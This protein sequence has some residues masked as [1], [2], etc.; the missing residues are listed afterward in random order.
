MLPDLLDRSEQCVLVTRGKNRFYVRT[1]TCDEE[2]IGYRYGKARFFAA[3][4]RSRKDDV[5]F[6]VGAHIGVFA[7]AAA[8]RVPHGRVYAMEPDQ[9][10]FALLT[11]N[12]ALNG[13]SNL[14]AHRIAL[15]DRQGKTR[16]YRQAESWAHSIC[17]PMTKDGAI[18]SDVVVTATLRGFIADNAISRIDYLKMNVEGA[19]YRVLLQASK[20]TLQKIGGVAKLAHLNRRNLELLLLTKIDT[21]FEVFDDE[22]EAV[23]SFFPEREI[24]RFDI[25]AFVQ[26]LKEEK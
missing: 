11:R 19:E 1:G 14:V 21:I 12:A 23:N 4:Y 2:V 10:N 3:G 20:R 24:R 16:L 13:L 5:I 18:G 26:Q 25:L 17:K 9:Q 8:R 22:T 15:S 7:V 6:D